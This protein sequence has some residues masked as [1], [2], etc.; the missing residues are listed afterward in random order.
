MVRR[1]AWLAWLAGGVALLL[2]TGARGIYLDEEQN[3][4]LRGLEAGTPVVLN[5]RLSVVP[6]SVPHRQE[7]SEVV[8]FRIDGPR[9]KALF[10]PDID[11]CPRYIRPV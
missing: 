8:G 11:S 10:I 1:Q 7:F 4:T 9:R 6:I 5:E 3:I 2:S